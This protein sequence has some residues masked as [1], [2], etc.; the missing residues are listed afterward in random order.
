MQQKLH[1]VGLGEELGD[2]RQLIGPDL[3]LGAVDLILLP[4]LPEL[5]HPAERI[6]S[7]EEVS[8]QTLNQLF[9]LQPEFTG[10]LYFEDGV[11]G[12][13]YLRQH[14]V[15]ETRGQVPPVDTF[16]LRQF[17]ALVQR[18]GDPELGLDQEL[19]L[20]ERTRKQH[21]VPVLAGAFVDQVINRVSTGRRID[22]ISQVSRVRPQAIAQRA[23]LTAHVVEGLVVVHC[24][25]F[26]RTPGAGLGDVAGLDDRSFELPAKF[27]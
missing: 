25:R 6:R 17:L 4:G 9:E 18:D 3:D 23:T 26:Q 13:E 7:R 15:R 19:V 8:G 24:K 12:P 5:V 16:F 2:G 21:P 22:A 1:H 14:F 20:G 10:E 11:I 27:G